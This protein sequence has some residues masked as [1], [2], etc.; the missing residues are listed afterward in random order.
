VEAVKANGVPVEYIVF[1]DEGHGFL[2]QE[3]QIKA[4]GDIKRFL[5]IQLK[6]IVQ[7]Q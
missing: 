4:Y 7:E 1:E 5:D 3:N 6:G 2:K